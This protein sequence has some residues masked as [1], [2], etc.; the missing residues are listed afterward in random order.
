M[1]LQAMCSSSELETIQLCLE[2]LGNRQTQHSLG[3]CVP[4]I[5]SRKLKRF[6]LQ[7][8]PLQ[9]VELVPL[10]DDLLGPL[11]PNLWLNLEYPHLVSGLWV[12]ALEVLRKKSMSIDT[13]F[14]LQRPWGL[15][16][17]AQGRLG[18]E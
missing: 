6:D 17:G 13:A 4:K 8:L 9:P 3:S 7:A 12:D 15:E 16:G 11:R 14:D 18:H 1:F 10:L 5:N 2:G